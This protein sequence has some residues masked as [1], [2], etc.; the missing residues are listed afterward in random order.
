MKGV[1]MNGV[2]LNLSAI[3]EA[4]ALVPDGAGGQ[5]SEWSELG[6]I[7]VAL[8]PRG[9]R[10]VQAEGGAVAEMRH[11]ITTRAAPVGHANRPKPGQRL[12]IASRLFHIKA[13]H[14][15]DLDGRYLTCLAEEE[16]VA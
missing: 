14:E 5:T 13:V 12:R 4:R 11:R 1:S 7:W 3:L 8:S 6:Q 15:A 10:L 2:R 9:G 16:R